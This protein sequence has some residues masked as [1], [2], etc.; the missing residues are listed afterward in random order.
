M[1]SRGPASER[2]DTKEFFT[3]LSGGLIDNPRGSGVLDCGAAS[4]T[5]IKRAVVAT[6][7]RMTTEADRDRQVQEQGEKMGW[8]E[9]TRG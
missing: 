4:A 8:S 5:D 7:K 9:K 1:D 3:A 2:A 6:K